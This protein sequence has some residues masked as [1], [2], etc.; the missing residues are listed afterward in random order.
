[1]NCL[2][3]DLGCVNE[4][5]PGHSPVHAAMH[6]MSQAALSAGVPVAPVPPLLNLGNTC[7]FNSALQLLLACPPLARAVLQPT[8][9]PASNTAIA[10]DAPVAGVP[11]SSD[12]LPGISKGPL[13]FALQQ[14]FVHTL[15][16]GA[17]TPT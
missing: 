17:S 11:S 16:R 5:S 7:Y 9:G 15:G 10:P 3:A 8:P 4:R 1:L 6:R 13:G 2:R 14:S 12:N